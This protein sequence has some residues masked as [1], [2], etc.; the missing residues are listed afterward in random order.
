MYME[1]NSG[2][3]SVKRSAGE[4]AVVEST[5]ENNS[6]KY[7]SETLYNL[8]S[9]KMSLKEFE[10][11]VEKLTNSGKIAIDREG[12]ICWIW[13]PKLVKRILEDKKF[14]AYRRSS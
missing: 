11:I 13:N 2:K 7:S 8:F 3:T 12:K 1:P 5:I 4:K 9:E 6:G 10:T 14:A